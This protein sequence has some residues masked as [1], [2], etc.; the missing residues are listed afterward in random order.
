MVFICKYHL[1]ATVED[2]TEEELT[3]FLKGYA[4][5]S[6]T[7]KIGTLLWMSKD[8]LLA[9]CHEKAA[10]TDRS[11][12]KVSQKKNKVQITALMHKSLLNPCRFSQNFL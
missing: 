1:N 8:H 6:I 12:E 7:R 5:T 11:S 10:K 2:V 4:N 3:T 9:N